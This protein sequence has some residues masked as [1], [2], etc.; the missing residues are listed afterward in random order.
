MDLNPNWPAQAVIDLDAI[1]HNVHALTQNAGDTQI[2]AIVKADAYGHGLIPVAEA[3]VDAGVEWLGVAHVA[4]AI[5]LR[6][7]GLDVPILTWLISP[8]APFDRLIASRIDVGISTLLGLQRAIEA[9]RS[10]GQPTRIH[11]KVVGE[12]AGTGF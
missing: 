5:A 1:R 2:M 10:A 4:E 7:A 9:G 11:V 6:Q 12:M 8:N 3:A